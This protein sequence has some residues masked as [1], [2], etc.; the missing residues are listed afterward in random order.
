MTDF[1][2]WPRM[3]SSTAEKLFM[4]VK[5]NGGP[6]VNLD[7]SKFDYSGVGK[8][9]SGRELQDIRDRLIEISEPYGFKARRSYDAYEL[10]DDPGTEARARLDHEY[11]LVF[12]DLVPMRWAEAGSSEVWSWFSLAF[13]PDLTHWRWRFA[14]TSLNDEWNRERWIGGDLPR[15]TWARYWWR[16]VRFSEDPSLIGNLNET[17]MTQ[18]LE[19]PDALGANPKLMAAVASRLQ[20]FYELYS[21]YYINTKS[22]VVRD[23][24][25]RLLRRLAYVD[26]AALNREELSLLV[27]NFFDEISTALLTDLSGSQVKD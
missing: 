4:T 11:T 21:R 1:F 7:V 24:M 15:H 20:E 3:D 14:S 23:V 22:E 2:V 10:A 27:D 12:H 9:K 5:K 25:K 19:R 6:D 26:D 17:E 8:R 18:L 16:T 13:L